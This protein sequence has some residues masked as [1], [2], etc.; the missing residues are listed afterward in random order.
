MKRVKIYVGMLYT[1]PK[2]ITNCPQC[3]KTGIRSDHLKR[4]M[5]THKGDTP[6]PVRNT[7]VMEE[8]DDALLDAA[9]ADGK[10]TPVP[11]AAPVPKVKTLRERFPIETF[12]EE[13]KAKCDEIKR[14]EHKWIWGTA[15]C[16]ERC[17]KSRHRETCAGV[18]PWSINQYG[19]PDT[20]HQR[21]QALYEYWL[22]EKAGA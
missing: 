19:S 15:A 2:S 9:I 21:F 10:S 8:S 13:K 12:I 17:A 22:K 4:H 11:Q 20:C 5:Q 6:V 3:G 1:M 7:V 14:Q 16:N 18:S